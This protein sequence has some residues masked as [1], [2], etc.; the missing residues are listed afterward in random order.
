MPELRE[1]TASG[2]ASL[3]DLFLRL[4]GGPAVRELADVLGK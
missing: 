1:Q 3:E 4:T 2:S